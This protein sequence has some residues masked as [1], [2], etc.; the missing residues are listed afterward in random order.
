MNEFDEKKLTGQYVSS[1]LLAYIDL[2]NEIYSKKQFKNSSLNDSFSF[3]FHP[4][5]FRKLFKIIEQ[6]SIREVHDSTSDTVNYILIFSIRLFTTHLKFLSIMKTNVDKDLLS[7]NEQIKT[8]T[9]CDELQLNNKIDLTRFGTNEEVTKWFELFLKL[10]S[11]NNEKFEEK[12]LSKE[13]SKALIYIIDQEAL[14]LKDR[15]ALVDKY[16]IKNQQYTLIEHFF[17][18]ANKSIILLSWIEVLCHKNSDESIALNV[19]YSFIDIYFNKTMNMKEE[20]RQEIQQIL[21]S[22]QRLLLYRLTVQ[23]S[24]QNMTDNENV[25]DEIVSSNSTCSLI[26]KY[27]TYVFHKCMDHN[28]T[29]TELFQEILVGLALM[30]KSE[31]KFHIKNVQM[32]FVAVLPLLVEYLYKNTNNDQYFT[33]WLLGKIS[34]ILITSSPLSFLEKKYS[35]KLKLPIFAGG[36]EKSDAEMSSDLSDLLNSNLSMYTKFQLED[37]TT[38]SLPNQQLLMSIYNNDKQG[39]QLISKM[40]TSSTKRQ[41]SLQK[42]I[43]EQANDA[44]AAVFAVY[45]KFYRRTNLA[46][47]DLARSDADKVHSHLLSL[48][49][50]ANHARIVFA[51]AKAQDGNCHQLH[52]QIKKRSLF[53]LSSIKENDFMPI[54]EENVPETEEKK[55]SPLQRQVSHWSKAKQVIRLLRNLMKACIRFKKL[56]LA[57]RQDLLRAY[58]YENI[59]K[60]SID[61]FIYGQFYN[62]TVTTLDE[63]NKFD[64]DEFKKCLSEQYQRAVTRLIAYRFV[65]TFTFHSC[66][67]HDQKLAIMKLN[68]YL[69]QLRHSNLEWSYLENIQALNSQLK[70]DIR[71]SYY[72]IVKIVLSRLMESPTVQLK[73][74]IKSIFSFLNLN[75]ECDDICSLNDYQIIQTLLSSFVNF[76]NKDEQ[77]VSARY[78]IYCIQL[79]SIVYIEIVCNYS[80]RRIKRT[81]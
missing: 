39:A 47:S 1:I 3:N 38:D 23:W 51:N 8:L 21:F 32:I 64:F 50:H 35:D 76:I 28:T 78:K 41:H 68:F 79:F 55:Q 14:S 58:S 17:S 70:T 66:N 25:T 65:E 19:L 69:A 46:K 12:I 73:M 2:D 56:M 11:H 48:Y 6:L 31:E 29:D 22:F 43:E 61:S 15:L 30:T 4:N 10:A 75:Y 62:L 49:E 74:W 59:L 67:M 16:I 34:Q 26:I 24:K 7:T 13:A 42:S 36:C 52:E 63:D 77:T 18:E 20:Q 9:S 5:T 54:I 57:G 27:I 72:H 53:L 80:F 33:C 40:R 37:R 44:C 60:R 71:Q 81:I 45:I